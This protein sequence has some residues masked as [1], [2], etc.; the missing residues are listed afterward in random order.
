LPTYIREVERQVGREEGDIPPPR[1]Y[2]T[3]TEFDTFEEGQLPLCLVVSPGLADRPRR[4]G[5]GIYIAPFLVGIGVICSASTE[6]ATQAVAKIYGAAVRACV[7]QKR[8]PELGGQVAWV[9]ESYDDIP[10]IEQRTLAAAQLIFTV[11]VDDVVSCIGGPLA[12]PAPEQ[13]PGELWGTV[14]TVEI[15]V[16]RKEE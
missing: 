13:Q 10:E 8:L 6:R 16:E 7:L 3:V 1:L 15:D 9:D 14:E 5:E 4:D 12:P 2:D 11:E